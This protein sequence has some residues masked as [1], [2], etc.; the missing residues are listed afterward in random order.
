MDDDNL[1]ITQI[2]ISVFLHNG[3]SVL[4]TAPLLF[5]CCICYSFVKMLLT[6][7]LSNQSISLPGPPLLIGQVTGESSARSIRTSAPIAPA[8][9]AAHVSTR[10]TPTAASAP[11]VRLPYCC[12]GGGGG[13][14]KEGRGGGGTGPGGTEVD[15]SPFASSLCLARSLCFTQ[16]QTH[17]HTH[18]NTFLDG[19]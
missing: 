13:G 12:R 5:I 15:L 8:W 17:T 18:A 7:S 4:I 9:T 10:S 1:V 3:E 19:H 11:Q 14:K 6:V 16:T 2:M